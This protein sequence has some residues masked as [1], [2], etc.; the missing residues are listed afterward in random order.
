MKAVNSL[1]GLTDAGATHSGQAPVGSAPST[2]C[3]GLYPIVPLLLQGQR[4]NTSHGLEGMSW[5][6]PNKL[7]VTEAKWQAPFNIL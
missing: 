4:P 3:R 5:M 2:G 7:Q 6:P 1:R